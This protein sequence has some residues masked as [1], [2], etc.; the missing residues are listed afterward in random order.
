MSY[1]RGQEGEEE[2][3]SDMHVAPLSAHPL[4]KFPLHEVLCLHNFLS[5]P[6]TILLLC[7]LYASYLGLPVC[8]LL[9]PASLAVFLMF[10]LFLLPL[11][12]PLSSFLLLIS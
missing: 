2:A 12:L 11:P 10:L 1:D 7:S 9:F 4:L 5:V 8:R 6:L 3:T